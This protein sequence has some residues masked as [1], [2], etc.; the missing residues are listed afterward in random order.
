MPINEF[1]PR[2]LPRTV[3]DDVKRALGS[4][5]HFLALVIV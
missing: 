4:Q 1:K 2:D 3:L 5:I